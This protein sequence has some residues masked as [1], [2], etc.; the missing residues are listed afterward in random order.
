MRKAIG[1]RRSDITAQFLIESVLMTVTGGMIGVIVGVGAAMLL[2]AFAGWTTSI[3]LISVVMVTAF[4]I[5]VGIVFG[6]RP[7]ISA[8]SLNPIEALRYE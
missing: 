6:L 3:S 4:S 5:V 8:A 2:S 1:A 7:A